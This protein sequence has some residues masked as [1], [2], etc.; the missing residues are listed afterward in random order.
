MKCPQRIDNHGSD[1]LEFRWPRRQPAINDVSR[2]Q[3][4]AGEPR[5]HQQA[6]FV[7]APHETMT[8]EDLGGGAVDLHN[9][10]NTYGQQ[11]IDRLLPVF[12]TLNRVPPAFPSW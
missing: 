3:R 2:L 6:S 9:K 7:Q 8:L 5:P 10:T 1:S 12:I 4:Y 11:V